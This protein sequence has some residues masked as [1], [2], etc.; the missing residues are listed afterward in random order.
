MTDVAPRVPTASDIP[1]ILGEDVL[2]SL[3]R[4]LSTKYGREVKSD[5]ASLPP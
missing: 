4:D 2:L 5:G 3:A 1:E